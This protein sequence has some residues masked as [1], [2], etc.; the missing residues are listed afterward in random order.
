M[1]CVLILALIVS[2]LNSMS[3]TDVIQPEQLE[4]KFD[5][6][7]ISLWDVHFKELDSPEDSDYE[8]RELAQLILPKTQ[9]KDLLNHLKNENSYDGERANLCHHDIEIHF[10]LNGNTALEIEMSAMTGNINIE[11]QLNE[12][13]F[14]NNCS[15]VFGEFMVSLLTE[16]KLLD[17]AG[18]DEIDIEGLKN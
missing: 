3:Q 6:V 16:S 15:K 5:S 14:R 10:Y 17:R 1:K 13:Y 8:S 12:Y 7:R 4:I 18:Y 2:P 11:N 9:A